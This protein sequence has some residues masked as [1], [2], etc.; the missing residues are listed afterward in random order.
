[1]EGV[2]DG[3]KAYG[4]IVL[5]GSIRVHFLFFSNGILVR[6]LDVESCLRTRSVGFVVL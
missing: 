4:L 2:C 3:K 1:M 5:G 6:R